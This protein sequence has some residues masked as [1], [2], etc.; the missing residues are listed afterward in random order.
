M[1]RFQIIYGKETISHGSNTDQTRIFQENLISNPD[2]DRRV[3]NG[4]SFTIPLYFLI[5]VSS[6]QIRGEKYLR[7][8]ISRLL[9]NT[10]RTR[11]VKICAGR[12]EWRAE[13]VPSSIPELDCG[14]ST[15]HAH[16]W[17]A[18]LFSHSRKQNEHDRRIAQV[19]FGTDVYSSL[20]ISHTSRTWHPRPLPPFP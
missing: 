1:T 8:R 19:F 17:Q 5:R 20:R 16:L 15:R 2:H 9:R 7:L 4:P 11:P 6:V 12:E 14:R 10:N 18:R 13:K 3:F